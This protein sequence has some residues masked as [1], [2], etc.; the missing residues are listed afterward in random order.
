[1]EIDPVTAILSADARADHV[2]LITALR[3]GERAVFPS[4]R[5]P[6]RSPPGPKRPDSW[7]TLLS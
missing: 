1:M 4:A 5:S 2:R 3:L 7:T 6:S